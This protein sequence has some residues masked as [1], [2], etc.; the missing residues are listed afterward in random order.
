M[1]YST[2]KKIVALSLVGIVGLTTAKA[3]DAPSSTAKIFG[4]T[5]QYRTWS[6]GINSGLLVPHVIIGGTND[7]NTS[8]ASLGY[9][10]T[11]R[12]QLGHAFGLELAA[13]KGRLSGS[14]E[15]NDGVTNNNINNGPPVLGSNKS[16]KTDLNLALSVSGVVNVATIDFLRRENA[17]NFLV[18]AG[19]GIAHYAPSYV[20]A[21]GVTVDWTNHAGEYNGKGTRKNVH[22]LF[23]P[24]GVGVKFKVSDRVNFDLGYN[25][26]FLD[27]DNLDATYAPATYAPG[28]PLA[29]DKWSYAYAGVEFSLGSTAKP[30]L[31]WVNPVAMMYDE[32]N[33]PT[34]RQEL[35]ALKGRVS[36]L[37]TT[38]ATLSADADGDGVSNK[39][40][41]CAGTPAGTVVDGSGCPIKF[42]EPVAAAPA[43][44]ASFPAIQFEFDSSVLR[45]SSYP[46]LDQLASSLKAASGSV[47]LEGHS[48]NEGTDKYNQSLSVDRSTSV[49]TY[50]VNAGVDASRINTAGYGETRPLASNATEE[51][52]IANRR[53]EIKK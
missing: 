25:M 13:L 31:D 14:N 22:E 12:K 4:G 24:V 17:V 8:D 44:P 5:A 33:D 52:R 16:F 43:A 37:E 42:P 34:L 11:L 27:G 47:T 38:V 21:S 3:Q 30:N 6:L 36:T 28:K 41:K 15:A 2:I 9:G 7:Y 49:K 23:I 39:F 40:D 45:T 19:M 29:K 51:G 18:K 50:L 48:S 26:Y 1:N 53:V 35:E 32:L 46:T 20:A 10:L